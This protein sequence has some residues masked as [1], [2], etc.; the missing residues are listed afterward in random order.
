[1]Q[2]EKFGI[3]KTGE[4]IS[5]ITVTNKNGMSM[6]VSDIGATLHKLCVPDGKGKF[7]D[8][9][10][11]YDTLDRYENNFDSFGATIGR[12]ANRIAGAT[13]KMNGET[14]TVEK[15]PG[16]GNAS[17]H[18]FPNNYSLRKWN[19]LYSE[20]EEGYSVTFFIHSPHM[21]QGYP[22]SADIE[23]TYTLTDENELMLTYYGLSDMDTPFNMTNHTFFN[24]NGHDSGDILGHTLQIDSNALTVYDEDLCPT[25]ET[26]PAEGT[27]YD[28]REPK[29]IGR[30]IETDE[31]L[32]KRNKGFDQCFIVN[33]GKLLDNAE[34]VAAVTGDKTGITMEVYTDLPAFQLYTANLDLSQKKIFVENG[35]QGVNYPNHCGL[36][37]ESQ[38]VPNSVN[39]DNVVKG[40]L[41]ANQ[42]FTTL[43]VYRFTTGE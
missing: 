19:Y 30:D 31:P 13:F 12:V 6:T 28:F 25:G 9:V 15:W 40:M 42:E 27:P 18:S 26:V 34:K 24:L 22:G 23:V 3:T 29:T 4:E 5:R 2:I 20:D 32:L 17:L 33:G 41:K 36:C 38:F 8:V 14:Y 16:Q 1:M 11:G 21:D 43:T 7:I 35:K 39:L 37:L 10:T